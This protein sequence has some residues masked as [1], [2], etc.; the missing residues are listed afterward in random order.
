M[1]RRL[2]AANPDVVSVEGDVD[3]AELR[4][5]AGALLD[6]PSE[7]LR[8]R[9]AARLDPDEGDFV[10][11]R[12]RLDDLVRDAR[13]RPRERVGVEEDL[14]G[15]LHRAHG[16]GGV[17]GIRACAVIRLLPGLTGPA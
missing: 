12:V 5:V 16:A 4:R 11:A 9:H 8:E 2:A 3:R 14:P 15:C 7:A 10:Q 1:Q 13:E 6:Q 17:A